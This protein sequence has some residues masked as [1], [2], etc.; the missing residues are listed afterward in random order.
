MAYLPAAFTEPGTAIE[1]VIRG[2]GVAAEVVKPPFYTAG[3]VRS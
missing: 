2:Q 3:T 1:I